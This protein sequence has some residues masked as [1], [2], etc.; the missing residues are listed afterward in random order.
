MYFCLLNVL[1]I[2]SGW[3]GNVLIF[4]INTYIFLFSWNLE[5]RIQEYSFFYY[6][7]DHFDVMCNNILIFCTI[8]YFIS[9]F[10]YLCSFS[11]IVHVHDCI[12]C[13]GQ[14]NLRYTE[15][16]YIFDVCTRNLVKEIIQAFV[17]TGLYY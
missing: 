8:V 16:M 13:Y 17:K 12:D 4:S 11:S 7:S 14:D 6:T 15:R 5:I 1:F 3:P 10:A 9:K 2:C